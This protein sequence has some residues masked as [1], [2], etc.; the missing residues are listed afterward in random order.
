MVAVGDV[1]DLADAPGLVAVLFEELGQRDYVGHVSADEGLEVIDPDRLRPQAR[2][3]RG[4]RRVA[5]GILTVRPIEAEAAAGEV[6]DIGRLDLRVAVAAELGPKIVDGDEE[7]V[8]ALGCG[9]GSLDA[10]RS[11]AEQGGKGKCFWSDVP[12]HLSKLW[13][14]VLEVSSR[15][16]FRCMLLN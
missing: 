5:K 15:L 8:H 16:V 9:A 13:C 1:E 4:A 11:E 6:V 3:Q 2:K 7:D 14:W 12:V 10:S